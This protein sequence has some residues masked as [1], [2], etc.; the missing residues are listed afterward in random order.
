MIPSASVDDRK[1]LSAGSETNPPLAR[2]VYPRPGNPTHMLQF[3]CDYCGNV[4]LEGEVWINGMAAENVGTHAARR[5]VVVDPAWRED[6]AVQPFA[7][8]FCSTECKD[9]YLAELFQQ[10][11]GLLEI[12]R[13]EVV[14]ENAARVVHARKKPAPVLVERGLVRKKKTASSKA[15]K[16]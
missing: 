5:E 10:P 6:R 4:K 16:R 15:R 11:P 14:P 3:V 12:E 1:R 9:Q 2:N 7:V 13:V 8:H